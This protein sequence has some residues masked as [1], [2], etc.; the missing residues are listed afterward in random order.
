MQVDTSTNFT[1]PL[2][3][4]TTTF[5]QDTISLAEHRYFWRVKAFDAAGNQG[6]FT[7]A[8]SFG[9]DTAAPTVPLLVAPPNDTTLPDSTVLLVWNHSTD[10]PS[11]VAAYRVQVAYDTAFASVLRDTTL[12]DTT[13]EFHLPESL[14]Y[15]HVR[16]TD[17]AGNV[18]SWSLRR[19]FRDTIWVNVEEPGSSVPLEFGLLLPF[20]QPFSA[21]VRLVY[22]LAKAED[23]N[24]AVYD[25]TGR[26]AKVLI[27]GKQTAGL[28]SVTWDGTGDSRGTLPRGTYFC[29][30]RAG[31]FTALRKMV[32]TE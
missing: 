31:E 19:R 2:V 6:H 23:V 24:L 8:D 3:V 13:R 25:A 20:P 12:A 15:W 29:Q 18:S 32:K 21:S 4:D 10:Q 1:P 17:R 27:D 22:G 30:L 11:G 7:G 28:W 16:A 14:F 26:R 5:T 9:V